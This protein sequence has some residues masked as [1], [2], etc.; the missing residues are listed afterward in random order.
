M[1]GII[2]V[3]V[4]AGA[5]AL[6]LALRFVALRRARRDRELLA[7]FAL[8]NR[9]TAVPSRRSEWVRAGLLAAGVALLAAV[10]SGLGA[11]GALPE[12]ERSG[13]ETVLVLDASNSM[14]AR[15]VDPS[16]LERQRALALRLAERLPGKVGVVYFAGRGYVLSPLTVDPGAVRMYVEAVAP[17][18]V[19]RGGTSLAGG[20]AEAL[21]VLEGGEGSMPGAVV[22]FSDGEETMDGPLDEAVGRAARLGV[23]V[24]AVGV[25]TSR[26]GPIPLGPDAAL[27]ARPAGWWDRAG[28]DYLRGSDGEVVITRLHEEILRTIAEATGGGYLSPEEAAMDRLAEELGARSADPSGLRSPSLPASWLLLVAFVLLWLEG[29]VVGRARPRPRPAVTAPSDRRAWKAALVVALAAITLGKGPGSIQAGEENGAGP[30]GTEVHEEVHEE[31]PRAGAAQ[32]GSAEVDRWRARAT[33]SDS[34]LDWYNL[35]TALLYDGRWEEAREPLR[36]A[37]DAEAERVRAYGR[38]NHGLAGALRGRHGEGPPEARRQALL[39]A[40]ESFRE[41][42]R[43]D[44]GDED[45]RWNLELVERWLET[46]PLAAA[47]GGDEGA[48]GG[49]GEDGPAGAEGLDPDAAEAL[50]EEA[51]RAEAEVRERALDRGRLRDPPVER[52]W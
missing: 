20:L 3:L 24:H 50:L 34:P 12:V 10:A 25:G 48:G 15:D 36:R 9:L 30:A 45:A 16:R 5:A 46:P 41:V 31:V 4:A 22:L 47:A 40:R 33:R 35:G 11:P 51:H 8:L 27:D 42:L 7:D 6:A 26:G 1:S 28:E 19:G 17:V 52:N 2:G 23:P 49:A 29:F 43:R 38:Y 44:S 32:G 13:P 21:K 14:L 37:G 18:R 39:S